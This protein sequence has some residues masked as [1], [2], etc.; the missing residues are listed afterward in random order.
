PRLLLLRSIFRLLRPPP[1]TT[2]FPYTTL[3]RSLID[4]VELRR[5]DRLQLADDGI[6]SGGPPPVV[7]RAAEVPVGPVVRQHQAVVLE[8]TQDDLRVGAEARDVELGVE[9]ETSAH[10]RITGATEP[11]IVAARPDVAVRAVG[12][13]ADGVGDAARQDLVRPQE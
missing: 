2:L 7:R 13:E 5:R 6:A 12:R 9:P 1:H 3:F 11:G 4:G 8:G 10:R